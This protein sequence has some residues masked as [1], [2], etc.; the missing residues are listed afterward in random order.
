MDRRSAYSR[1]AFDHTYGQMAAR[2]VEP[3]ALLVS[4]WLPAT[5]LW[6]TQWVEARMPTAQVAVVDPLE[7]QWAGLVEGALASGRPAY[8]ARPLAAA[9]DSHSLSSAGPLVRVLDAP[10]TS[11]PSMSHPALDLQ[12]FG[13]AIRLL[14]GDLTA[15]MP[16]AE[17][18]VYA[19]SDV[20]VQGGSTL[21][22]TLYWQA[23]R[24]PA[25]D[26]GVTLRLVRVDTAGPSTGRSWLERY[27]RHPV[28]GSYPTSRWQAGEV[29]GDYYRLALPP[30]LPSGEYRLLV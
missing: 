27:N 4:D 2:S 26:Y 17:G 6:Y 9:G 3:G 19:L 18:S 20:V 25:G 28:G 1:L 14:G 11:A 30:Y 13:G 16:G 29:V 24:P 8:L 10:V 21:H 15:S 5:V 22:I 7:G 12:V 23:L